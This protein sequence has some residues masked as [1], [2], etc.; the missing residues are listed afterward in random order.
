V[1]HAKAAKEIANHPQKGD[2]LVETRARAFQE[3]FIGALWWRGDGR[4]CWV[5]CFDNELYCTA[6]GCK[7]EGE[8]L[9][10]CQF[11]LAAAV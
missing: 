3:N 11:T 10:G 1:Q 5:E 6:T 4:L 9:R 2:K 8:K 7:N